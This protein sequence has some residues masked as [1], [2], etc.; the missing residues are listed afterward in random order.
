MNVV[1]QIST[2]PQTPPVALALVPERDVMAKPASSTPSLPEMET[3]EAIELRATSMTLI[4]EK[5][6]AC[7]DGYSHGGLND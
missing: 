7:G 2:Q 4:L 6:M 5:I 1:P 3:R